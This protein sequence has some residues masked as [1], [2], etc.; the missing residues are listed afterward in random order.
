MNND[1]IQSDLYV[2]VK[3]GESSLL[4]DPYWTKR[5]IEYFPEFVRIVKYN[6]RGE[7]SCTEGPAIIWIKGNCNYWI[8]D[9]YFTEQEYFAWKLNNILT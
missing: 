3:L 5:S 6:E 7:L 9:I 2:P 4:T 8:D 1:N